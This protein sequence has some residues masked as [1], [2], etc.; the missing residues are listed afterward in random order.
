MIDFLDS[1]EESLLN[2]ALTVIDHM[3]IPKKKI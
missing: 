3:A 1:A 2:V